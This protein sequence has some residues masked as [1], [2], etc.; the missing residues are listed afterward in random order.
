MK[1]L[2]PHPLQ[3]LKIPAPALGNGGWHQEGS[4]WH[5]VQYRKWLGA[6]R[7][8]PGQTRWGH[9]L[10][11]ELILVAEEAARRRLVCTRACQHTHGVRGLLREELLNKLAGKLKLTGDQDPARG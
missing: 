7:G 2:P 3:Y 1:S 10:E 5:P 4:V 6:Q 9:G 8:K 11:M